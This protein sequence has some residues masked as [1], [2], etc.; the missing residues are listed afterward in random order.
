MQKMYRYLFTILLFFV[1][2]TRI[3]PEDDCVS[4]MIA[5]RIDAYMDPGDDLNSTILCLIDEEL[6]ADSAIQI[7]LL[8]NPKVQALYEDVGVARAGLVEAGLFTNPFVGLEIRYPP[9]KG[10]HTNI[11]Y[12]ITTS[13]LDIFLIPLKTRLA[14]TEYQQA[15]LLVSNAIL[16]LAF[17]VRTAFYEL[18]TEQ[19]IVKQIR[20]SVEITQIIRDITAKQLLAGNVDNLDLQL[21]DAKLM[22]GQ[23]ELAQSETA[24]VRLKEKLN[25]LLGFNENICLLLPNKINANCEQLNCDLSSLECFALENRLDMQAARY[26]IVRI[27]QMLGLKD[28]WTYTNVQAGL[29]GEREADG[30]NLLG[31]GLAFEVPLFNH[32]QAARMRLYS[33]LSQAQ[34]RLAE[35]E[36][37]VVSETREAYHVLCCYCTIIQEYQNE[38]LPMQSDIVDTSSMLYNVM[39]LGI[40]KLLE[41]KQQEII[42]HKNYLTILREYLKSTVDLDRALGGYLCNL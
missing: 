32:G 9:K 23:L 40:D 35:L 39:G 17:E 34:N 1:G 25:R 19:N 21:M 42:T 20:S 31:P 29:A 4:Q 30:V 10:L 5:K 27:A 8:N 26:E 13:L 3:P 11:E 33:Q 41:S 22:E 12:L 15:K 18:I 2:C 36:I 38:L 37:Q 14:E 24:V 28:W 6:T 16:D 7:A